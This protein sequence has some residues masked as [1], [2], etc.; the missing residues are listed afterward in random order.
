MD[1]AN[2]SASTSVP[3]AFPVSLI[4]WSVPSTESAFRVI[5]VRPSDLRRLI[6]SSVFPKAAITRSGCAATTRSMF[7]VEYPPIFGFVVASSG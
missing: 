5:T 1:A 7:T 6:A 2:R 3:V 4:S